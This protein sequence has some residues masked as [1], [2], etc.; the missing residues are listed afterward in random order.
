M[1]DSGKAAVEELDASAN[2]DGAHR[3]WYLHE[4][5]SR[6]AAVPTAVSAIWCPQSSP[7]HQA[8]VPDVATS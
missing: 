3:C 4:R 7:S 5:T 1:G 2:A 8:V 6:V